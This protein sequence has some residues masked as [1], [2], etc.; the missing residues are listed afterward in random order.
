VA[1][2][3]SSYIPGPEDHLVDCLSRYYAERT[4][5]V[6]DPFTITYDMK[7]YHA[8]YE[9]DPSTPAAII[10]VGFMLED[11]DLLTQRPDIVARGIADG[12]I[13]F[14]SGDLP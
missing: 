6:F 1:R 2:A 13:C 10:E 8:Y 3:E 5:L 14:V 7:R 12:L 9:I 4:G 11:R